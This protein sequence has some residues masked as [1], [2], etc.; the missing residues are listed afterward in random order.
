MSL[1][2]IPPS[3]LMTTSAGEVIAFPPT[4]LYSDEPPVETDFHREQIE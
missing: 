2:N 1:M 3:T 4:D